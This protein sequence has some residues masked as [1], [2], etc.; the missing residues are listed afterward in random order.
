MWWDP[1]EY[2]LFLGEEHM[3]TAI[4]VGFLGVFLYYVCIASDKELQEE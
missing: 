3:V 1:F 4:V 2:E